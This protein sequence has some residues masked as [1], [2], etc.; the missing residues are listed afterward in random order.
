MAT[1]LRR[2]EPA[3]QVQ[4]RRPLVLASSSPRR[5]SILRQLG[6]EFE[7]LAADV[8]ESP[9]QGQSPDNLAL[10]LAE[11]KALAVA[12]IRANAAVVAADTVVALDGSSLGKPGNASEAVTML[13][14]LSGRSHLVHTGVAVRSGDMAVSGIETTVVRMRNLAT[15]EIDDYVRSGAAM[16]KAGAYG[17]QDSEFSP[18]ESIEGS[19]LNVVGLPV[20][21]LAKLLLEAGEINS[22]A[23]DTISGSDAP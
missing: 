1:E 9:K 20:G 15:S 5:A 12:G 10:T 22:E 6:M 3:R 13:S 7:V 21:L 8:D 18:V 19:Y 23:A 16:D 4:T 17:I 2:P 14:L 11:A